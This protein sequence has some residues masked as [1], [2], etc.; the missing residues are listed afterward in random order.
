MIVYQHRRWLAWMRT[1]LVCI[2]LCSFGCAPSSDKSD[3]APIK[4][5]KA[6]ETA[7]NATRAPE[8]PAESGIS[9]FEFDEVVDAL[10]GS[11]FRDG[12][13]AQLF[14]LPETVGGGVAIVDF[15]RDGRFDIICSGGG[16]PDLEHK[17]MLGHSGSVFRGKDSFRFAECTALAGIN[18]SQSYNSAVIAADYDNDGFVDVLVTGYE[19][20]QLFH[21]LGDGTFEL[22]PAFPEK[23]WSSSAAFLDADNDGDL[24]LYAVHYADWSFDKNPFCPSHNDGSKRDYCGPS[25]FK[26]LLDAFYENLGDGTFANR[27]AESLSKLELR[28]LGVIAADLDGDRDA[29]I[30]VTNDVDQNLLYRNDKNLKLTEMGRRSGVAC[31]DK[32]RPEGSMGVAVGDYNLD[33]KFDLW[34][35]NYQDEQCALYRNNGNMSFTYASNAARITPTDESAVGW[36]TAFSDIDLDGDEDIIIINGHL[37]RHSNYFLQRPQLLENVEGKYFRL[38]RTKSAYF[39]TPQAGRGLATADFDRDGMVDLC[40]TRVNTIHAVVRNASKKIGRYLSLQLIGSQSNRD[41]IG[42]VVRLTVGKRVFIRQVCGGGSYASTSD[43]T[44]HFGIPEELAS[45]PGTLS[46]SWP[47]GIDQTIEVPAWNQ[48]LVSLEAK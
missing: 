42:T 46:I 45:T 23:I 41:A 18:M 48:E 34:V 33:G 3:S 15:D 25:D 12:M 40:V 44:I 31:D 35:T 43:R 16:L 22:A 5:I 7:S 11:D 26:G 8:T 20:L 10:P 36:G 9:Q 2:A 37:E 6:P 30:Y 4:P 21:N 27:T 29:D 17:V 32:G 19:S 1:S 47:S 39:N 28:G 13:E 38:H 14:S 24:D